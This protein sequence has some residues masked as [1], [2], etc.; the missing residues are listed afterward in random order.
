MLQTLVMLN[1]CSQE[2]REPNRLSEKNPLSANSKP[3]ETGDG[4]GT[5]RDVVSSGR[6]RIV[7]ED[8]IKAAAGR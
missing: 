7:L 1:D 3:G 5:R 4:E 6:V 8:Q 2:S